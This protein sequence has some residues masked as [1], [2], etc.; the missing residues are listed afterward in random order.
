MDEKILNSLLMDEVSDSEHEKFDAYR[1]LFLEDSADDVELMEHE[2]HEAGMQFKS[3]RVDNKDQ[4]LKEVLEFNPDIILADYSLTSF[5]GMQAF[6]KLNEEHISVPFI[7]VTGVLSEK[8]ALDCLKEG[9]DDFILKSS[10]KRLPAAIESAIRKREMQDEKNR[11]ASELKKSH[12]ELR[13]LVNRHQNSIEE[14][15]M[16]IARD[17]HD[18]LGQVLTALKIDIA[19]LR[20]KLTSGKRVSD[21]IIHEEFTVISKTIDKIAMSAKEISSGLRPEA[22]DDLGILDAIQWQATEFEK[23]NNMLCQLYLPSEPLDL[24]KELS[25]TL[26]RIVQEALTNVARHSEATLVQIYMDLRDNLL[27]IEILDNGKGIE[28]EKIKS[29]KSLGI[30]GLRERVQLLH[31]H[32]FIGKAKGGGTKV[33]IM[34]PK[35]K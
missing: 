4:F 6:R 23:R 12:E 26:Y 1:I 16:N 8:L 18:E 31:G 11:F 32:F 28:D 35:T 17:L 20:K 2:L 15:R 33:S 10:F 9:V 34:L 27:F 29:S 3:K 5:N 24:T 7:L 19:L 14:E 25:I 30:I 13:Q 22:L 21:E